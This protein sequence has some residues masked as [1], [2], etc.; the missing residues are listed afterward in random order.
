MGNLYYLD[1]IRE[2]VED[3]K[4]AAQIEAEET[5]A[6]VVAAEKAMVASLVG[7]NERDA[8]LSI[9]FTFVKITL[10]PDNA[11]RERLLRY[12]VE[13]CHKIKA[14]LDS[15]RRPANV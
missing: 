15:C 8:K 7:M 3:A 14:D 9:D 6:K 5:V 13:R 10:V 4:A 1:Q 12:A 2:A 11:A